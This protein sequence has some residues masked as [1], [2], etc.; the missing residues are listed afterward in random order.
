MQLSR[1]A[2]LVI[3]GAGEAIKTRIAEKLGVEKTTVYRW[4]KQNDDNLTKASVIRI[5]MDE[6]GLEEDQLLEEDAEERTTV[7]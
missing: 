7:A 4:I 5:L 6:S 1:V 3:K 2:K